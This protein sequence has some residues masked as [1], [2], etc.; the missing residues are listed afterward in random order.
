[1]LNFTIPERPVDD[2]YEQRMME[3]KAPQAY[4]A[5]CGR[6]IFVGDICTYIHGYHFC[7]KCIDNGTYEMEVD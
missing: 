7:E 1:M 5:E 4:C 2:G 6:G 3:A